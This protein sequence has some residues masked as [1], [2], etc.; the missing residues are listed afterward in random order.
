MATT[1]LTSTAMLQYTKL[2]SKRSAALFPVNRLFGAATERISDV[3]APNFAKRVMGSSN[4]TAGCQP[5]SASPCAY[6]FRTIL[7]IPSSSDSPGP[8]E[9]DAISARLTRLFSS[10][11]L[12]TLSMSLK[13]KSEQPKKLDTL[14]TLYASEHR[15]RWM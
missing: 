10:L 12:Q 9:R 2:C 7:S 8:E 11:L 3:S 1:S 6:N 5:I 15:E 4:F 14:S 13:P